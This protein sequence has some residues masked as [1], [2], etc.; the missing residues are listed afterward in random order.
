MRNTNTKWL[1]AL[2]LLAGT[3]YFFNQLNSK[4]KFP[5]WHFKKGHSYLYDYKSEGIVQG[6]KLSTPL[7][8]VMKAELIQYIEAK[9][10]SGWTEEIYFKNIDFVSDPLALNKWKQDLEQGLI[11]KKDSRGKVLSWKSITGNRKNPFWKRILRQT[12][13]ILPTD[14][15]LNWTSKEFEED[16]FKSDYSI[17][18]QTKDEVE[19]DKS[20]EY[21]Q[22]KDHHA[23]KAQIT[24]KTPQAKV[25]YL[26]VTDTSE[27]QIGNTSVISS[28]TTQLTYLSRDIIKIKKDKTPITILAK[29]SSQLKKPKSNPKEVVALIS[30]N[31]STRDYVNLKKV[32]KTTQDLPQE[33][34]RK[35]LSLDPESKAFRNITKALMSVSHEEHLDLLIEALDQNKDSLEVASYLIA[36]ISLARHPGKNSV[37]ALEKLADPND[38]LYKE[39]SL[40][41]G[42]IAD[43]SSN[44]NRELSQQILEKR[45]NRINSSTDQAIINTELSSI[46]N[47]GLKEAKNFLEN[48][49]KDESIMTQINALKAMRRIDDSAIN[50]I[51]LK[52]LKQDV[53]SSLKE[54]ASYFL[55]QRELEEK[56]LPQLKSMMFEKFNSQI[57]YNLIRTYLKQAQEK[58]AKIVIS[59]LLKSESSPNLRK[60]LEKKYH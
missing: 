58:D 31:M 21:Y 37:D 48:K 42:V 60:W 14:Q 4:H 29:D 46:G 54:Q 55:S 28:T 10:K 45:M 17:V 51:Y 27:K 1:Q 15:A 3:I 2:A 30:D 34:R 24:V 6:S 11:V 22:G 38:M 9:D 23:S 59:R 20:Y 47:M 33:I 8:V 13:I 7:K 16:S 50:E 43:K 5:R 41:L 52:L 26:S 49:L 25:H 18:S 35:Y 36:S 40:G 57:K 19:I 44:T 32:L 12:S 39:A 56:H 53:S